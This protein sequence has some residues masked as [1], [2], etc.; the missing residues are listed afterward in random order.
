[1]WS[2][3][4]S[5]VLRSQ[6]Q[7][8]FTA[9]ASLPSS[10]VIAADKRNNTIFYAGSGK[11]FYRSTDGGLTF[12]AVSGALGSATSVRDVVAH[13][14]IAGEALVSTNEGLFR[15]TDF[16]VTLTKVNGLTDTQHIAFG[17]GSSGW[18]IY[19]LGVGSSGAKLYAS[20]DTGATWTDIQGSQGFGALSACRVVG[21]SNV[22]GQVYV[23]TNGRGV[24][25]AKGTIAG[26]PVT[27]TTSTS[28]S[29]P[30]TPTSASWTSI[31]T[32]LV[33]STTSSKATSKSTT[34]TWSTVSPALPTATAVVERWGQC[35]GIG[36]T[37][38]TKCRSP[39]ECKPQNDWYY[40]CL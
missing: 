17:L 2:T 1:M 18:N 14:V 10:A 22:A 39:W 38:A 28:K 27:T 25:Y 29:S 32:T 37:G 4:N 16:G 19:A 34:T 35:G 23:G 30:S 20:A 11:N 12:T 31:K 13:P 3:D 40:Q 24:L 5:G 26:A 15:S 7:G 6:N 8:T 36:W 33:T 21:S 9:V